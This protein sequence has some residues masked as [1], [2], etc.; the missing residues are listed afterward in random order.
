MVWLGKLGNPY[1]SVRQMIEASNDYE[2]KNAFSTLNEALFKDEIK[3]NNSNRTLLKNGLKK[4]RKI[5]LK[6]QQISFERTKTNTD[7]LNPT[8]MM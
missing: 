7:W 3:N 8:K 5:Y 2:L 6:D 1:A 4:I